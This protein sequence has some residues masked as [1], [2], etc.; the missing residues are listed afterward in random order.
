MEV[1]SDV[2][3]GAG[4][5]GTLAGNANS[6]VLVLRRADRCVAGAAGCDAFNSGLFYIQS[7]YC[8]TQSSNMS[9]GGATTNTIQLAATP[10]IPN[11]NTAGAYI[12]AL[13]RTVSGAGSGQVRRHHR[14]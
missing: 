8:A 1:R 4:C 6:D 14:L 12:G 13:L 9:Q 11:K 5:T 3:T 10:A 7:G 2:P